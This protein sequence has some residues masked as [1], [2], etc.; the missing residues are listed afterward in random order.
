M[1]VAL[2]VMS[3]VLVEID[4]A[5]VEIPLISWSPVFVPDRLLKFVIS[6]AV[7][8]AASLAVKTKSISSAVVKWS[9]S[10]IWLSA[11]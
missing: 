8:F 10:V 9:R 5:L 11:I 3:L 6:V 1:A 4:V 7:I 2:V